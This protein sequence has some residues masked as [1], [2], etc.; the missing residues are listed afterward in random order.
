MV[1][2]RSTSQTVAFWY[3]TRQTRAVLLKP[4][5]LDYLSASD[6]QTEQIPYKPPNFHS[7]SSNSILIKWF[8]MTLFSKSQ[9]S[10]RRTH[11]NP[12]CITINLMLTSTMHAISTLTLYHRRLWWR[13]MCFMKRVPWQS[14]G[15]RNEISPQM[16]QQRL[17]SRITILSNLV[18]QA[19]S[20]RKA[21]VRPYAILRIQN[22]PYKKRRSITNSRGSTRTI[23]IIGLNHLS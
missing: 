23:N 9:S 3:K 6:K 8:K 22:W 4:Q 1:P 15:K 14:P 19:Q 10:Q 12:N 2:F 17:N 18:A 21:R 11:K 13:L 7:S 5:K 20:K 16:S